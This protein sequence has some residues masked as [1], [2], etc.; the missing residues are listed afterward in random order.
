M[1]TLRQQIMTEFVKVPN[2]KKR[3]KGKLRTIPVFGD[4]MV[5]D[6]N[7]YDMSKLLMKKNEK[8]YN[9]VYSGATTSDMHHHAVP[10]M[11]YNPDCVILHTGTNSLRETESAQQQVQDIIT[12]ANSFKTDEN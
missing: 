1:T 11:K 10:V 7:A 3:R 12:L 8:I 9:H 4:S 6:L 5:K 2:K